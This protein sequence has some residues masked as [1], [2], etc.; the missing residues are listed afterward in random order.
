[1]LPQDRK[2]DYRIVGHDRGLTI[3]E[4][5]SV[6]SRSEMIASSETSDG[7]GSV[8]R[9]Q[10]V[11]HSEAVAEAI[12]R[13]FRAH[14]MLRAYPVD[15]EISRRALAE[16]NERLAPVL[17]LTLKLSK[18]GL[19]CEQAVLLDDR[20]ETPPLVDSLFKDG[21]RRIVLERGLSAGELERLLVSLAEAIDP[22]DLTEDYVTRLWEAELSSVRISAIDPYLDPEITNDVL[23]GTEPPPA[24]VEPSEEVASTDVP[25]PPDDAFQVSPED[26]DRVE[27]D[28]RGAAG[29][30]RWREFIDAS[31]EVIATSAGAE[32]LSDA[33][34]ALETYFH[35]LVRLGQLSEA[36]TIVEGLASSSSAAGSVPGRALERMA[37]ADRLAPLHTALETKS[38]T[39]KDVQSILVHLG[40]P[41]VEAICEFLAKSRAVSSRRV[42]AQALGQIADPAVAVVVER[43]RHSAEGERA[44][45][46]LA[47]GK[48]Q[49]DT[50]VSTLLEATADPDHA[51]R[52]EVVRALASQT[53]PRATDA[54][55]RLS[56][57][58]ANP[59][60]RIIALR[61]LGR[62]CQQLD[63]RA[64][65][66]RVRSRQ[67]ASLSDEE[68]TLLFDTVG[69]AADEA[70]VPVLRTILAPSW[71]PGRQR[72][73]DWERA[74]SA[75]ARLGT[76]E[77]IHVLEEFSRSRRSDL[78][79]VC[80]T[81]LRSARETTP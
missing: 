39:A 18:N 27:A 59:N 32:R 63:Q 12:R 42:C 40:P 60:T 78:A 81:A 33:V 44:A 4:S 70:I 25:P 3:D 71:I 74:A 2:G 55:L 38:S 69:G 72:R 13:F 8:G 10:N 9:D 77:A 51:V 14:R 31:F 50:V 64:I 37:S 23:E 6:P 58:D 54:L 67:Y 34:Q 5:V 22:D 61:G 75:L 16:V 68:K 56:L 66:E 24:D 28:V 57:E 26:A 47:L 80:A 76:P 43:F 73:D 41:A 52:H 45:Y 29:S 20:G 15:N 48:L 21:I 46:A 17:P 19:A 11:P 1:M 30:T 53:D 35:L 65:L 62:A 49:G 7:P 79:F 36:S